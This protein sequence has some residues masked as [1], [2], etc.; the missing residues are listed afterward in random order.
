MQVP[1]KATMNDMT[2]AGA[3]VQV[4]SVFAEGHPLT[5]ERGRSPQPDLPRERPQQHGLPRGQVPR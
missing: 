2:V 3:I 1:K 5:A 4:P